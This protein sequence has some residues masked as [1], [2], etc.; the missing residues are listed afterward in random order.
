MVTIQRLRAFKS[1]GIGIEYFMVEGCKTIG[2]KSAV[3]KLP[4]KGVEIYLS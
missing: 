1:P 4:D 3:T 2:V